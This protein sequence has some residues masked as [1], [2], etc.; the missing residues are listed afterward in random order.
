MG[1]IE[2]DIDRYFNQNLFSEAVKSL[3]EGIEVSNNIIKNASIAL[4]QFIE[5]GFNF[6]QL[7]SAIDAEISFK[8]AL[9]IDPK[10]S[11]AIKGLSRAVALDQV[12]NYINDI[13]L[14]I[15]VNSLDRAKNLI[16]K[17]IQLDDEYPGINQLRSE[18]DELIQIR[19]LE[20]LI[21]DGFKYLKLLRFA[22]AKIIFEKA[23]EL[24]ENSKIA[25][26]GIN[27]ANE[28]IKK[29]TIEDEKVFAYESMNLEDFTKSSMHFQNIL[30]LDPNIQFAI[31]GLQEVQNLVELEFHLDRYLDRPERLSSPNVF[32][33][34]IEILNSSNSL[35]L[36]KRLFSKKEKLEFLLNEYANEINIILFSD[37]KTQVSILN[38][39]TLGTFNKKE[40]KLYPGKYTFIGK[41]KGFVTIRQIFDFTGSTSVKIQCIEKL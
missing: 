26:E 31:L 15:S 1:S 22:D 10:N 32:E 23:L 7:N 37:N 12:S 3:N 41:R 4:N 24:E 11:L 8:K 14:L 39:G 36:Q 6:L 19:D 16:N 38:V 28:G 30:D 33:E 2:K 40:I 27:L 13:N 9:E 18:I 17:A 34:A 21:S 25:S 5:S 20:S 35:N 29:N